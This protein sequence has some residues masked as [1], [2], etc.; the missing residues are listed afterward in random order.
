MRTIRNVLGTLGLVVVF[1]LVL[2]GCSRLRE[3]YGDF[4]VAIVAVSLAAAWAATP[5]SRQMTARVRRVFQKI[6]LSVESAA[7]LMRM[8]LAQLSRGLNNTEQ[9]SLSRLAMLG[10][11]F[12]RAFACELA[13]DCGLVV[14]DDPRLARLVDRVEALT[15]QREVA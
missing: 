10:P 4:T 14:I 1:F 13:T 8:D 6:G 3:S 5:E 12:D 2:V 7:R 9:L 11:D 15:A